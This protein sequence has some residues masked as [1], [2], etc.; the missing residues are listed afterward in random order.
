MSESSPEVFVPYLAIAEAEIKYD[1][2]P[3]LYLLSLFPNATPEQIASF[4]LYSLAKFHDGLV[5]GVRITGEADNQ[6]TVIEAYNLGVSEGIARNDE[7][8]P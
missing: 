6:M 5:H 8:K 2:S 7:D 4:N 1:N 3:E